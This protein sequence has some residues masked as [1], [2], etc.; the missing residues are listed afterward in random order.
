MAR[1]AT[2]LCQIP[3]VEGAT[4]DVREIRP[5]KHDFEIFIGWPE[6]RRGRGYGGPRVIATQP[7][8]DFWEVHRLER[9]GIIYDLPISRGAVKRVRALL[10]MNFYLDNAEWWWQRFEDLADM[11][12]HRFAQLHG[13]SDSMVSIVRGKIL[14]PRNRPEGW[15]REP[16]VAELLLSEMAGDLL[17]TEL[18][19]PYGSAGRLR[20]LLRK[21]RGIA[22]PDPSNVGRKAGLASAAAANFVAMSPEQRK[23]RMQP[24]IDKRWAE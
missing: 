1:K 2:I 4:W 5:T 12:N 11:S 14:G 15:W 6:G 13:V 19:V 9:T 10:G 20:H 21:E 22:P 16:E 23:T 24:A 18:G 3:D 17:A 8:L 7:M